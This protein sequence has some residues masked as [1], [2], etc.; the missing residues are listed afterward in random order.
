MNRR[1]HLF[2]DLTLLYLDIALVL[3]FRILRIHI[4]LPFQQSVDHG[5]G[6]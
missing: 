6:R 2:I 3:D 4:V 5:S 1:A